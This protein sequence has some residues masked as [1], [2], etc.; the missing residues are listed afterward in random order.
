[1]GPV[2]SGSIAGA[3]LPAVNGC[4]ASLRVCARHIWRRVPSVRSDSSRLADGHLVTSRLQ[5]FATDLCQGALAAHSHQVLRD[6]FAL[7]ALATPCLRLISNWPASSFD[8]RARRRDSQIDTARCHQRFRATRRFDRLSVAPGTDAGVAAGGRRIASSPVRVHRFVG[9]S[10]GSVRFVGAVVLRNGTPRA[11]ETTPFVARLR[12]GWDVVGASVVRAR[13]TEQRAAPQHER[14]SN[15]SH[16]SRN[17][18]LRAHPRNHA[19]MLSRKS[20]RSPF[21]GFM[22]STF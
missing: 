10:V 4:V 14:C 2:Y 16:A 5:R 1:M 19:L 8:G 9:A 13:D 3:A 21:K 18:A 11:N 7:L 22:R 17:A 15:S 12:R 20:A 6:G